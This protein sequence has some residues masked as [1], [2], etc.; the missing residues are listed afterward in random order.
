[1]LKD[2]KNILIVVLVL[3]IILMRTCASPTPTKP[4]TKIKIT[5]EYVQVTETIPEYIPQWKERIEVVIDTFTTPIDTTA[6]LVDYYS[7]YFYKDTLNVDTFGYIVVKDT[8]SKNKIASRNVEYNL[9]IP[10]TTI[11]KTSYINER[12]WYV[13]LGTNINNLNYVGGEL[14]YKNKKY[15]AYGLGLGINNQFEPIISGRMYWRINK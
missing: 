15:Q 8:I 10:I 11:E 4:R 9:S 13:G 3:I 6:I 1:M 14:L 5:T 2:I 7:K 12:E